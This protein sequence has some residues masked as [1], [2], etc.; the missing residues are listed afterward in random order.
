MDPAKGLHV[1]AEAY[2]RVREQVPARLLAAGYLLPEHRSYLRQI[3]VPGFEYRGALDRQQ[4]LAF[5]QELDAFSVP[6]V[7]AEPKGLFL[8]EAMASGAPVVQ[9][10][11]GAFPEILERTGGGFLVEPHSPEALAEGLLRIWRNPEAADR[12]S[13]DGAAGV[14]QHY[15]AE[16][17]ARSAMEVFESLL[18]HPVARR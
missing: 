1:L 9:P 14:R 13:R 2:Q 5:L 11:H 10:R 16:Q 17:M 18:A 15:T 6:T 4:K 3:R 7:Y 12:M 8:L